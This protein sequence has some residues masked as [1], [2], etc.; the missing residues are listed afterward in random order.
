MI[1]VN[2][3]DIANEDS[4]KLYDKQISFKT[5]KCE[6]DYNKQWNEPNNE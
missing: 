5:H 2:T 1:S 6:S 3:V 4:V